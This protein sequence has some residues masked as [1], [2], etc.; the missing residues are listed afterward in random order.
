M[1]KFMV[2]YYNPETGATSSIDNIEA[3][4]YY[5]AEQYIEDCKDNADPDWNRMLAAGSITLVQLD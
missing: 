3:P 4:E 5:T 2:N 1:A